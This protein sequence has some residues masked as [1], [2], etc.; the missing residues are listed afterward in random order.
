MTGVTTRFQ[1]IKGNN[2]S[3]IHMNEVSNEKLQRVINLFIDKDKYDVAK[4]LG[5]E[6]DTVRRYLALAKERGM[7]PEVEGIK[8]PRIFVFD[9]ENAPS[10][11][12][13]WRMWK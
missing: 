11:A 2:Q 9:L 7:A 4:L 5:I 1:K 8:L 13:V 3:H 6:V 12:A 10:K